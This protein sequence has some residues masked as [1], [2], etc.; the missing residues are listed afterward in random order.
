MPVHFPEILSGA[1]FATWDDGFFWREHF[2]P[3]TARPYLAF[4][5]QTVSC[6]YQDQ[7]V[8][9]PCPIIGIGTGVLAD[10]CDVVLSDLKFLPRLDKAI[11]QS[12]HAAMVLVQHLRA[13]ESLNV[14]DSLT[15]ESLAYAC[16]QQGR[17]H[18]LW[19]TS[20]RPHTSVANSDSPLL[21]ET[22]ENGLQMSFNHSDPHNPLD[23]DMRDNLCAALQQALADRTCQHVSLRARGRMFSSGGALHEFGTTDDSSQC[24]WIRSQRP[25]GFYLYRLAA[26]IPVHVHIHGAA[27]GAGLELAAFATH[28]SAHPKT[29]FQLPELQYGL[30]PGAGG[31]ASLPPRIGRQRTAYMALSG[32]RINTHTALE[33]GLIDRI[34]T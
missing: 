1:E 14:V 13:T 15:L 27:I 18:Q 21:I 11:R 8:Q 6:Q 32:K 28:I 31:T 29:W 16:L 33:W 19:L 3:E 20:Q 9:M 5:L 24:H 34:Q 17:E 23:R 7:L 4:D 30:I 26:R 10:I 25:T 2:G 22:S 12:P